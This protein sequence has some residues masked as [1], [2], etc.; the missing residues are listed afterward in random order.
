MVADALSVNGTH[1]SGMSGAGKSFLSLFIIAICIIGSAFGFKY[2]DS[3]FGFKYFEKRQVRQA[4]EPRELSLEDA[5]YRDEPDQLPKIV[6][7]SFWFL[8]KFHLH[9]LQT[10][11]RHCCVVLESVL[12]LGFGDLLPE[13]RPKISYE[14]FKNNNSNDYFDC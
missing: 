12:A 3:A 11:S 6:W 4:R 8:V 1:R 2:F 14:V 10:T 5:P 13:C 7:K 9:T